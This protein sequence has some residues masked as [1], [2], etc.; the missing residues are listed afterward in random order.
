MPEP[1]LTHWLPQ[2]L[3]T[4]HILAAQGMTI[5][6]RLRRTYDSVRWRE[7]GARMRTTLPLRLGAI[8]LPR[9]V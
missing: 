4:L 6:L 5:A 3:Q 8:A 9:Q 2:E 7:A 1:K